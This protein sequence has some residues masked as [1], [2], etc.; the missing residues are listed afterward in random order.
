M[1]AALETPV[2]PRAKKFHP[3]AEYRGPYFRHLVDLKGLTYQALQDRLNDR[4]ENRDD[5]LKDAK[6]ISDW[7]VKGIPSKTGK[8]RARHEAVL[9]VLGI[10]PGSE[11]HLA[12]IGKGPIPDDARVPLGLGIMEISEPAPEPS[13]ISSSTPDR[14][15]P[16]IVAN[17]LYQ[18]MA[19]DARILYVAIGLSIGFP[20]SMAVLWLLST[21]GLAFDENDQEKIDL[22]E[23]YAADRAAYVCNLDIFADNFVWL[24][25]GPGENHTPLLQIGSLTRFA[26]MDTKGPWYKVKFMTGD[27]SGDPRVCGGWIYGKHL[28]GPSGKTNPDPANHVPEDDVLKRP[29]KALDATSADAN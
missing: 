23:A 5:Q 6:P 10:K 29:C 20:L 8:G 26:I 27:N 13:A 11:K 19:R 9:A 2:M 3:D 1:I 21:F 15:G 18:E 16:T 4:I 22:T 25:D 24:R 14:L 12:L 17:D 28:C 7:V